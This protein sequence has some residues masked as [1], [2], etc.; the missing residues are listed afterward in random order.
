MQKTLIKCPKCGEETL[1]HTHECAYGMSFAHI[2]GTER[3]ECVCGFCCQDAID[4]AKLGLV[5]VLDEYDEFEA[6]MRELLG[7]EEETE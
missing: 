7:D 4:G 3:F 2:A 1:K 5:F 6:E